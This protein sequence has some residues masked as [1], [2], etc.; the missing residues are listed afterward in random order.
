MMNETWQGMMQG[1]SAFLPL[2]HFAVGAPLAQ[3]GDNAVEQG[4]ENIQRGTNNFFNS[5]GFSA[6]DVG[7]LLRALAILIIGLLI[8][9]IAAS[10]VRGI[11]NRTN[12][13]NRVARA[14]TGS[15]RRGDAIPIEKWL[16]S[17]VFWTIAILTIIGAL[18][19]LNL[20]AVSAPLN[21]FVDQIISYIPKIIAAGLLLAIAG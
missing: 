15:Q 11:L 12:L 4:A 17:L 18:N 13:D 21:N 8:A 6:A 7:N 10:I 2:P 9:A 20:G 16:S 19:A 5:L 14:T 1:A 3:A